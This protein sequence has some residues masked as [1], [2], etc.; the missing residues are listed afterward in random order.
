[1]TNYPVLCACGTA[2]THK[3]A[4]SWSDGSIVEL[5]TYALCC[6]ECIDEELASAVTRRA[7]CRLT[8]GETLEQP[9]VFERS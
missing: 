6:A 9:A 4:A 1:M 8:H 7:A 5:K 3:I 2:A